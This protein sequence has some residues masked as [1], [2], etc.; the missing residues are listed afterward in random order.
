MKNQKPQD[1]EVFVWLEQ[2]QRSHD[3]TSGEHVQG[4]DTPSSGQ[5]NNS[6]GKDEQPVEKRDV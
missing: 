2:E 3:E 6:S 5:E 4:L 1:S